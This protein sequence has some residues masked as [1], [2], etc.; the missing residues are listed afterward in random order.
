MIHGQKSEMKSQT[1]FFDVDDKQTK[2]IFSMFWHQAGGGNLS[3]T[4]E[5]QTFAK[6]TKILS[7]KY[8]GE[9]VYDT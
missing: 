7:E 2:T 3:P 1:T 8:F 9:R 6:N 5:M 4:T